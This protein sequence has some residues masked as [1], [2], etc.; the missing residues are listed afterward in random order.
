MK[1]K[2][3]KGGFVLLGNSKS[4]RKQ[5]QALVRIL[6][7]KPVGG[8]DEGTVAFSWEGEKSTLEVSK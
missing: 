3:T 4:E 7:T 6:D 5:L 8:K 2:T 1:W